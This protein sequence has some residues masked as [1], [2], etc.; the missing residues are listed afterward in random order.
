MTEGF[1]PAQLLWKVYRLFF[2]WVFCF[3]GFE[4][5]FGGFFG[6]VFVFLLLARVSLYSVLSI[7]SIIW[8]N[9]EKFVELYRGPFQE[10][11]FLKYFI[12]S[13]EIHTLKTG[14]DV[15]R[16]ILSGT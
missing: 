13:L 1:F 11:I 5:R 2:S 15:P 14:K 9:L 6:F 4:F 3:V 16:W 12:T 7:Y 10:D 8:G